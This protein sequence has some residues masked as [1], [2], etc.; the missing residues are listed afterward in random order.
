MTESRSVVAPA[1]GGESGLTKRGMKE[2]LRSVDIFY[3]LKKILF[4]YF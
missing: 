4:I 1:W 2:N 3:I